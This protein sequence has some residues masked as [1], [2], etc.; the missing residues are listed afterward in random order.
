MSNLV[1]KIDN[2]GSLGTSLKKWSNVHATTISVN[3][4]S[5]DLNLNTQKIINLG[6]P[7][8]NT[9]AATKGYI[10]SE[11]ASIITGQIAETS[12]A[13][14]DL[15]LIYDVSESSLKKITKSN[16]VFGIGGG[17]GGGAGLSFDNQN[18]DFNAS[19]NFHYS[20]TTSSG[21][22]TATLP[23]LANVNNGDQ[24]RFYL[25]ERSG[26]NNLT[27]TS[28]ASTSDTINGNATIV[29]DVQY[30]SITI[31]ANA[32]NNIWEIV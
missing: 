7:D 5:S 18:V 24:I 23:S 13:D 31:V 3:A 19:I 25:R 32:T 11:I 16:F 8:A 30:D 10:D 29:I 21:T 9:D 1:P 15:V 2:T 17:G 28:A 26:T 27:I 14:D 6:N 4:Q 20:I 12:I 22:V